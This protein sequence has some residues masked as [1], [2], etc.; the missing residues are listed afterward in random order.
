[1][2]P[3]A[4]Y[5]QQQADTKAS[6]ADIERRY[7]FLS[8]LRLIVFA[9][10]VGLS[11]GGFT[12]HPGL[13]LGLGV[14]GLLGFLYLVLLH[15]RLAEDRDYTRRL[16]RILDH[17]QEWLQQRL[18]LF[19][20]GLDWMDSAQ[21]FAKDLDVFGEQSLWQLL[22]RT[23]TEQGRLQLK[24]HVLLQ[25]LVPTSILA[26]QAAAQELAQQIDMSLAFEATAKENN[27]PT[28]EVMNLKNWAKEEGSF[29]TH[30]LYRLLVWLL[31]ALLGIATLGWIITDIPAVRA[32]LG[33]FQLSGR[34]PLALFLGMLGIVGLNLRQTT[35]YQ[36][37][38]SQT[39]QTLRTYAKLLSII[40]QGSFESP[41][42]QAEQHKLLDSQ[43]SQ[44]IEALSELVYRFDQRLNVV[45]GIILNGALL[46]DIRYLIK[47]DE[48]RAKNQAP[49]GIWL[50]VVS[51]WD[52]L[53]SMGRFAFN[54]PAYAWPE[55]HEGPFRLEA[56]ELGHPLINPERRVDNDLTY[57]KPGEFLIIT[58]ANMAGKS[59]FLRTVGVNLILA[60][61]GLPVCAKR[62]VFVPTTIMTSMRTDDSLADDASYFFSE[63][64][65]LKAIIDWLKQATVPT[66]IILDE[67]LRGTNSRDKQEGS[68]QF[69]E[70][71]I[72]LGGVG[73][74]ATHDLAMGKMVEAY[75]D[76]IRNMRFEVD[77]Q[78][79]E[80]SFDYKLQPG[81]SQNLNAVFLMR[82]MGI[83][84]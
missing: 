60:Q 43:A 11:Y 42:L 41:L 66:F 8:Y 59:T 56:A 36:V 40:E 17:E 15:S 37:R 70:Q 69:V 22:N 6:L 26:H 32:A 45:M 67:I 75:P 18:H 77:I 52:V 10:G 74:V 3:L 16:L 71:L 78:E 35:R 14:L 61:L 83:M 81:I 76:H 28:A 25:H 29:H 5:Q 57:T 72:A 65:R 7:R 63:L 33:G 44:T 20:P 50:S 24:D 82:K 13:G 31:P 58:G 51:S 27:L 30:R 19:D 73:M 48:W 23:G 80:L 49:L 46:W 34:F 54:H 1:M 39:N 79:D 38:I 64:V 84:P 55:P 2:D 9:G 68:R 62:F 4:Y 53:N 21:S 47:L 12:L